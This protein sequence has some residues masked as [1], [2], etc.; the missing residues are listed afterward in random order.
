VLVDSHVEQ[1]WRTFRQFAPCA[2]AGATGIPA[3]V[4]LVVLPRGTDVQPTEGRAVHCLADGRVVVWEPETPC[5]EIACYAEP[6]DAEPRPNAVR[7]FGLPRGR[8]AFACAWSRAHVAASLVGEPV[9]SWLAR[10]R[11]RPGG[12]HVRTQTFVRPELGLVVSLGMK[13]RPD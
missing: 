13:R 1:K 3:Y 4:S 7:R 8:V 11:R 5:G 2:V 10:G 9:W 6:L 12:P